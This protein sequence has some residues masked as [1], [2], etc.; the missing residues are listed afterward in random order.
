CS[1]GSTARLACTKPG[2]SPAV[3]ARSRPARMSARISF[4]WRVSIG[5]VWSPSPS[6][7]EVPEPGPEVGVG[8]H[9]RLLAAQHAEHLGGHLQRHA[10]HGLPGDPGDMG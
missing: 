10:A 6:L 9:V 8:E 2:A 7:L 1:F 4:G 3:T 5:I